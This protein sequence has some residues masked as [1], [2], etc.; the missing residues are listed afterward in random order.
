MS[1]NSETSHDHLYTDTELHN[2]LARAALYSWSV[3]NLFTQADS[4]SSALVLI[5]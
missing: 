3:K 1:S 2:K 5:S 4:E